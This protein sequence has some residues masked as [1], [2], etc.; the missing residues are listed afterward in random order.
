MRLSRLVCSFSLLSR[1]RAY[2]I[3]TGVTFVL[4]PDGVNSRIFEKGLEEWR[5]RH[6]AQ[7]L[8]DAGGDVERKDEL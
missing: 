5:R 6:P 2:R 1:V 3:H 8:E 4:V 7:V